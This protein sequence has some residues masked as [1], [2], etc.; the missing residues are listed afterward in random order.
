MASQPESAEFGAS[1]AVPV[2]VWT[3]LCRVRQRPP[4]RDL[5]GP[6]DGWDATTS[7][8]LK[9]AHAVLGL[10]VLGDSPVVQML[11]FLIVEHLH[12]G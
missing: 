1:V 5:R 12:Y 6:G 7:N 2:V 3:I 10:C 8:D 9:Y 4:A 11:G